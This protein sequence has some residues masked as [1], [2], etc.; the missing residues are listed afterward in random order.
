[1]DTTVTGI[2]TLVEV[3]ELLLEAT[4]GGRELEG[5]EEVGGLLEVGA[6][7][8]DLVDKILSTDDVLGAEVLL[9]NSVVLDGK[10]VLLDLGET[11]LVD[12]LLHGLEGGL[13]VGDV[14]LNKAE[15]VDGGLVHLDEDGVVDLA[16]TEELQNL[17]DLGGVADDTADT[18]DNEDLGLRLNKDVASLL[19]GTAHADKL[20]ALVVVLLDVVLS[21][22]EGLLLALL[23]GDATGLALLLT[24]SLTLSEGGALLEHGLGN[25]KFTN[26]KFN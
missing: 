10:T 26:N 1:V 11:A 22:L 15:H 8:V 6:A 19:G 25:T 7:S 23:G 21:A 3:V 13:T 5:P 4:L 12:K 14:G 16:K 17:A 18:G 9:N 24:L 2:T 20:V